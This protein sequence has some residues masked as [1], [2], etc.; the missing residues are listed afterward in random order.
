MQ[1]ALKNITYSAQVCHTQAKKATCQL[2]K[3]QQRASV[4]HTLKVLCTSHVVEQV[5]VKSCKMVPV[6]VMGTVL[7]GK[8]YSP[9]E[10]V[11]MTLIGIGVAL[12]GKKGSHKVS[13]KLV[14]P[15]TGG[16]LQ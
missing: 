14:D 10:Y 4:T 16:R 8:R 7:H 1:I 12:F 13:S 3:G 9:A 11:C 15:N 6:M 5:L 2:R